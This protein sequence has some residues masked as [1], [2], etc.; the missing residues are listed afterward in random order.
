[1]KK[2]TL[3]PYVETI[4]VRSRLELMKE[5]GFDCVMTLLDDTTNNLGISLKEYFDICNEIKLENITGH[6]PYKEPDINN[7]WTLGK[8]GRKIEKQY[9]HTLKLAKEYKVKN[10]V[11]HLHCG[12]KYKL[13]IIGILR[14]KRLLKVAEKNDINIAV[15]NLYSYTELDYILRKF[16]SKN[17]GMCYDSGH[18]NFLTPHANFLQKH[19][20]RLMCVHLHDNNGLFHLPEV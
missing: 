13:N 19:G 9:L 15:E 12:N 2:A 1:M 20:D 17:L 5:V 10:I 7:F 16:K 11:V 6:A 4:S 8:N 14:L 3:V 18:E